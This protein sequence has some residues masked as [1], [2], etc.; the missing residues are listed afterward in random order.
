[1]KVEDMCMH[2]AS[3]DETIFKERNGKLD[4]VSMPLSISYSIL[5]KHAVERVVHKTYSSSN[6]P[7]QIMKQNLMFALVKWNLLPVRKNL[8]RKTIFCHDHLLSKIIMVTTEL[9][10]CDFLPI[11]LCSIRSLSSSS[12]CQYFD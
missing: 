7:L 5:F 10:P 4:K 11:T 8:K 12:I 1:M 6:D 9:I 3:E 2:V